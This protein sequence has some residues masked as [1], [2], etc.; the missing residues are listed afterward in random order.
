VKTN[1]QNRKRDQAQ[2]LL[3]ALVVTLTVGIGIGSYLTLVSTQNKSVTRSLVWNDA[4]PIAESGVEEAM[5]QLYYEDTNTPS[6][7]WTTVGGKYFKQR[8]LGTNGD[9]YTVT[10]QPAT[11]PVITAVGYALAPLSR[12]SYISRTVQVKT[13]K[14]PSSRGGIV[15]RGSVTFNGGAYLDSFDS[16]NPNYS[17][18]GSYDPTKRK[19]NG[20]VIANSGS[21]S[22][23][24]GGSS[25]GI[26]GYTE[27]GPSGTV[28][29][30]GG[31]KVGDIGFISSST[32]SGVE[33]GHRTDDANVDFAPVTAPSTGG[34]YSPGVGSYNGTNYDYLLQNANYYT[35]ASMSLTGT[36]KMAIVGNV[37]LYVNS[38][39]SMAGSST[40]YM[41]PGSSLKLYIN[42][43]MN[44]GGG[45]IVNNSQNASNLSIY[46]LNTTVEKWAYSGNAAFVGTVYAPNSDFKF[47]GSAGA[48]GSFTANNVF[49]SGS[50]G[51][52]YDE[53]LAP[54]VRGYLVS[55]WNEL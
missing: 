52:H 33:S 32:T 15:A 39:F 24:G 13:T 44:I 42:G 55:S 27:T 4:M 35:S 18:K 43:S 2:V 40:I 6:Q 26:Y 31:A 11:N 10:I 16:S 47:S 38:S 14:P 8:S 29:T 23:V 22:L 41:F 30:S 50:A 20:Q 21:I 19:D 25:G 54:S 53:H 46:G 17:T 48:S 37:T 45:G 9:Y 3:S 34:T 49:V 5:T 51:I 28:T 12:T 1:I 36:K 7:G